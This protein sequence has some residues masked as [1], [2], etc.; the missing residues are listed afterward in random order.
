MPEITNQS[1]SSV[2]GAK[3]VSTTT[4][5]IWYQSAYRTQLHLTS[6]ADT[7][8]NIMISVN[9][10]ILTG[11]VATQGLIETAPWFPTF[12]PLVVMI[13]SFTSLLFAVLSALPRGS[14]RQAKTQRQ[15]TRLQESEPGGLLYYN[16]QA[17][18]SEKEFDEEVLLALEDPSRLRSE[19]NRHLYQLALVLRRKYRLLK[20]SYI[21]FLA[22]LLMTVLTITLL[23]IQ[24]D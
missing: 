22:G 14:F 17:C 8:A 21:I 2:A 4:V 16:H 10:L 7:K 13:S 20:I 5:D 11:I 24:T 12:A 18:F 19:M 6:L 3:G 9:G 15:E 23:L 1:A